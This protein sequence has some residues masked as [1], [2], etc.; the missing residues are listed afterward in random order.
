MG[1]FYK[2]IQKYRREILFGLAAAVLF[3]VI[4]Y[5]IVYVLP[6]VFAGIFVFLIHK[7]VEFIHKKTQIGKGFLAGMILLIVI[8]ILGAGIWYCSC[9][10]IAKLKLLISNI[11]FYENQLFTLVHSCC[12]KVE[13]NLGLSSL[14]IENLILERVNIFIDDLKIDVVPK[15]LD[16]TMLYG[17]VLF[18]V[19]MF[20]LVTIIAVVLL[21]K[22]Y[23]MMLQKVEGI[24]LF[25][26]SVMML[27]KLIYLIGAYLR[28]QIE[29]ILVVSLICFIGFG[30]CGYDYPYVWGIVTGLLD[31]LPFV[32][33]GVVL[34]PMAVLQLLMGNEWSAIVLVVTFIVSALSR[35]ILEPKLIGARMGVIPIAILLSVYVGAKVFGPA[36]VIWGPL[37][38]LMLYEIYKKIYR[39]TEVPEAER[40]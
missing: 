9:L 20:V 32:G 35:E 31:V 23:Q 5:V 6:F 25:K 19:V 33:T 1:C 39:K 24:A 26:E 7:P 2:D 34:L 36:G 40:N 15:M 11:N 13:S 21:A 38:M 10:G 22:D 8:L 27:K 30:L 12:D 17:K 16:R 37:Y 14:T 29:I 28:A 18:S 3:I 4:K